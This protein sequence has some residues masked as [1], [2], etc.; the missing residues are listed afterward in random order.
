MKMQV[1]FILKERGTWHGKKIS[2][3]KYTPKRKHWAYIR[4]LGNFEGKRCVEKLYIG[5]N[6]ENV[7]KVMFWKGGNLN[8]L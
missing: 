8:S 2:I 4:G 1:T 3:F 7:D 6:I 5:D